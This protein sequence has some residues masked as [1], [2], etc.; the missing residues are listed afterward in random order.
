MHVAITGG[1]GFIAS[2]LINEI[3]TTTDYTITATVRSVPKA[4]AMLMSLPGAKERL[5]FVVLDLNQATIPSDW[6]VGVDTLFHLASPFILHVKDAQ[7]DLVDPAVNG[8]TSVL[9]AAKEAKTVK[10]V[11]LTAS[12]AS[13]TD[14]PRPGHIFTEDDWNTTSSLKRNPYYYSK[15]L[16]EKAAWDFI[17]DN[18]G[19]FKLV[20]IL[21]AYVIGPSM[22][23]K[24]NQSVE[25]VLRVANGFFPVRIDI[26][27][28]LVDVRDV[29]KVHLVAAQNPNSNGR[30]LFSPTVNQTMAGVCDFVI[31]EFPEYK[32]KVPKFACPKG[33]TYLASYFYPSGEGTYLRTHLGAG[34]DGLVYSNAKV[35]RELGVTCRD[36]EQTIKDTINDLK[37]KWITGNQTALN[38][39]STYLPICEVESDPIVLYCLRTHALGHAGV[40][41]YQLTRAD[42]RTSFSMRLQCFTV[43]G[44]CSNNECSVNQI[45]DTPTL[46]GQV[47]VEDE[48]RWESEPKLPNNNGC[49]NE[50]ISLDW[51]LN[52]GT[53]AIDSIHILYGEKGFRAFN[54][55]PASPTPPNVSIALGLNQPYFAKLDEE[56]TFTSENRTD[57]NRDLARFDQITFKKSVNADK[58]ILY[59]DLKPSG[60][61]TPQVCEMDIDEV[62]VFGSKAASTTEGKTGITAPTDPSTGGAGG[63][64][65]TALV[66]IIVIPVL[67]IVPVVGILY[68]RSRNIAKRKAVALEARARRMQ[69]DDV[70]N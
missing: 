16:A 41:Y 47:D 70:E 45:K 59:W 65:T 21:P 27:W 42:L 61:F 46:N 50:Y 28:P 19:C 62:S 63:L 40:I 22:D 6:L 14:E 38:R 23:D 51:S 36:V 69:L 68:V 56:F 34:K 31:K 48:T 32:K 18:E 20:T 64:S 33:V 39:T 57:G 10:T 8:T 13:V 35:V 15:T 67:V 5:K 3:L 12:V 17:K 37:S 52:Y 54:G 43:S 4:E 2:H 60:P 30:Y 24:I 58:V 53:A 25:S 1:T 44:E 49:G 66:L 11:V 7:R 26:S 55:N 29:A 9:K